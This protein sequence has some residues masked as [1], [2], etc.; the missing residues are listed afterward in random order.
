MTDQ[1]DNGVLSAL[2]AWLARHGVAAT[3]AYHN[4][5]RQ[6]VLVVRRGESSARVTFI[7]D[8]MDRVPVA[9]QR[10]AT[11]LCKAGF[12]LGRGR[13]P[14]LRGTL[15]DVAADELAAIAREAF[16]AS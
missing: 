9:R 16:D 13:L 4:D 3:S 11:C 6:T 1:K 5:E 12:W 10:L 15:G 7:A 14:Q 8:Q 2:D